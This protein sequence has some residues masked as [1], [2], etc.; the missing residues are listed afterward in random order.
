MKT[1]L[2]SILFILNLLVVGLSDVK[3]Q[4]SPVVPSGDSLVNLHTYFENY[5][6]SYY[7]QV[8]HVDVDNI[9]NLSLYSSIEKWL[10]TPYKYAGKT[11]SGIDCSAFVNKVYEG[12]YCFLLKG[13]SS[14][15]YS[16][17]THL[18][19][20]E[21][22]EGD[23]VFFKTT[24]NKPI[25]HVGVYLG[26][27]KFVHASRSLGVTISDLTHPYYKNRFVKG[28]RVEFLTN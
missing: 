3:A 5:L 24:K 15:M 1:K 23:L 11:L 6:K 16:S 12:A 13:N 25:S 19:K 17:V 10:G 7:S 28:G 18:P 14:S 22:Q 26:N 4:K 8:F 9:L 21:L 27:N 20:D 2:F